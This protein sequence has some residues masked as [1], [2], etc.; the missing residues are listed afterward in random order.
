MTLEPLQEQDARD[1]ALEISPKVLDAVRKNKKERAF[2]YKLAQSLGGN[3][4]ALKLVF[5]ALE[6]SPTQSLSELILSIWTEG[7]SGQIYEHSPGLKRHF[8][9]FLSQLE[10]EPSKMMI[11]LLSP[12]KG[13]V[14]KDLSIYFDRLTALEVLPAR[15]LN[16]TESGFLDEAEI[17]QKLEIFNKMVNSILAKLEGAGFVIDE[18]H[19]EDPPQQWILHPLLPYILS[20]KLANFSALDTERIMNAHADFYMVRAKEWKSNSPVPMEDMEQEY[21]NFISSFWRLSNPYGISIGTPAPWYLLK[22]LIIYNLGDE[23]EASNP[24]MVIAVALCKETLSRFQKSSGDWERSLT[25]DLIYRPSGDFSEAKM[26]EEEHKKHDCPCKPLIVL[27][28][29]GFEVGVYNDIRMTDEKALRVR[30][31]RLIDLW[32][33]H[34]KHFDDDFHYQINCG[35]GGKALMDAGTSY[36]TASCLHEALECLTRAQKLLQDSLVTYPMFQYQLRMCKIHIARTEML[37]ANQGSR[38]RAALNLREDEMAQILDEMWK[39]GP[40]IKQPDSWQDVEMRQARGSSERYIESILAKDISEPGSQEK[41]FK[42]LRK[43]QLRNLETEMCTNWIP[44]QIQSKS[45]MALAASRLHDWKQAQRLNEDI[46]NLLD[47]EEFGSKMERR[48][49]KLEYHIFAA[50]AAARGAAYEAAIQHLQKGYNITQS[51][52][53]VHDTRYNMFKIL[54]M[55]SFLPKDVPHQLGGLSPI[56]QD[57]QLLTLLYD[58]TILDSEDFRKLSKDSQDKVRSDIFSTRG[59]MSGKLIETFWSDYVWDSTQRILRPSFSEAAAGL[60]GAIGASSVD[61]GQLIFADF[62]KA[63]GRIPAEVSNPA[64]ADLAYHTVY[65]EMERALFAP[66]ELR[67]DFRWLDKKYEE[68]VSICFQLLLGGSRVNG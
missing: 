40:E 45:L 7:F 17:S 28:T 41:V 62:S 1:L 47:Q 5:S 60:M 64:D 35:V 16:S 29:I 4:L 44:G 68:H 27:I 31:K 6:Q 34:E 55:A 12:F 24:G 53:L 2:C 10:D 9:Y 66:P 63:M 36:L 21:L 49:K 13:Y 42:K 11:M 8:D 54:S 22:L 50:Q 37:I 20:P 30:L 65:I 43:A 52:K 38:D 19:A 61:F 25:A 48:M 18:D 15:L 23:D 26:K 39:S 14:P 51:Y 58:P 32:N 3:P 59:R 67:T 57:L 46:L 56:L 33:L